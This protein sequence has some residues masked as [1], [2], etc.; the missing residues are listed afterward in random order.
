MKV[1][2]FWR[3]MTTSAS[4][5]VRIITRRNR[6]ENRARASSDCL[7]M[8]CMRVTEESTCGGALRSLVVSSFQHQVPEPRRDPKIYV[9]KVMVNHVMRAQP[10][11]PAKLKLKTVQDMVK[12]AVHDESQKYAGRDTQHVMGLYELRGHVP[13]SAENCG[14]YEPWHRD[15]DLRRLV[16]DQVSGMRGRTSFMIN[17]SVE[18][19][20]DERPGDQPRQESET[21]QPGP[22]AQN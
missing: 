20:F 10:A 15:Q 1:I 5:Q 14:H 19:V 18:G 3:S 8:E 17:P 22:A 21:H 16:M 2:C 11:I 6:G 9:G 13:Q 7:S 4:Y 12:N